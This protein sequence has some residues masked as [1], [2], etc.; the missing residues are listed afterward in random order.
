MHRKM[1]DE[2]LGWIWLVLLDLDNIKR[3]NEKKKK[4][5]FENAHRLRINQT[6]NFI[7]PSKASYKLRT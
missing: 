1:F 2:M 3:E 6:Y 4:R 5:D 7:M